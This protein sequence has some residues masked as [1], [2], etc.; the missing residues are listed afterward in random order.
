MFGEVP[1]PVVDDFDGLNLVIDAA[2]SQFPVLNNKTQMWWLQY[3]RWLKNQLAPQKEDITIIMPVSPVKSH[4]DISIIDETIRTIR[5]HLPTSEIIVTFDGVREEQEDRRADYE[6]FKR[7][8]LW[9]CYNNPA[10]ENILPLNFDE[11]SHQVK[12]ARSALKYVNTD[13][14]M[15]ME[16]DTPLVENKKITFSKCLKRIRT[17][18]FNMIRFHFE[19]VV[20]E[21]HEHMMVGEVDEGFLRT[22]Q[23]SQRP[24][25]ISKEYFEK[26]L[27]NHFSGNAI[28]FI[29]DKMHG[30]VSEDYIIHGYPGWEKH[31]LAIYHPRGGIKRSYHTDG[32]AGESK[33]D[34]KQIW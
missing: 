17:G 25:L 28:C 18:Y 33:W 22:S 8:F 30:I 19:D 7:R 15:Y 32:R 13:I 24:H 11:H 34:N 4:P 27:N 6:E 20:P 14:V 29:E 31:K 9:E 12:M 2:V 1:F 21:P 10:Y 16:Q 26:I 23:W 5:H 3:R